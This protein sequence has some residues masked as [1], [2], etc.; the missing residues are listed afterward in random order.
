MSDWFQDRFSHVGRATLEFGNPCGSVSGEGTVEADERGSFTVRF[1]VE[2]AE[3]LEP[4]KTGEA[5]KLERLLMGNP[6]LRGDQEDLGWFSLEPR[7][8]PTSFR[9]ETPEG[10]LRAVGAMS[11]WIGND[12]RGDWTVTVLPFR[13]QY[14]VL[15]KEDAAY[16]AMPLSNFVAGFLQEPSPDVQTNPLLSGRG[17]LGLII[18]FDFDGGKAFI[19]QVSEYDDRAEQLREGSATNRVTSVMVGAV[20]DREHDSFEAIEEWLPLHLL[21]V[22]GLATGSEVGSP[23]IELRDE[24]GELVRRFYVRPSAP[25]YVAGHTSVRDA[26]GLERLGPLLSAASL[27]EP[28][29]KLNESYLR[30][31]I[32][33]MVRA[34]LR[35]ASVEDGVAYAT[36][37]IDALCQEFGL[38]KRPGVKEVLSESQVK[39]LD[40]LLAGV[41][42]DI[43]GM[44]ETASTA[45]EQER[46]EML[47]EIAR[48]TPGVVYLSTGFNKA[49]VALLEKFDLPDERI[50]SPF[51]KSHPRYKKERNFGELVARYR[52]R[53]LHVNY[54]GITRGDLTKAYNAIILTNHLHDILLRIVFKIIGYSGT[55][56]PTVSDHFDDRHVDWVDDDTTPRQLGYERFD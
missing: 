26:L 12:E 47:E 49:V 19:E 31:T 8:T 52:G 41:A 2:D 4:E 25:L 23:W 54:L 35:S 48:K 21:G 10:V 17:A 45:G 6:M 1:R 29:A 55:Y 5:D 30:V 46:A 40:A 43:R 15:G 53:A 28:S 50:V 37:A 3:Y 18:E 7:N 22:L 9:L 33:L 20:G 56:N 39:E 14:D 51:I 32:K 11:Y 44:A 13:L 38:Q 42:D 36:R 24:E 16:W 34:K 27:P